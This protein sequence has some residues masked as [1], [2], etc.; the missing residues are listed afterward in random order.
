MKFRV[1]N[2]IKDA[3]K[4]YAFAQLSAV[5]IWSDY[6][7]VQRSIE[8]SPYFIKILKKDLNYWK[9]F[10]NK[11]KISN[12]I[13]LGA[14]VGEFVILIPVDKLCPKEKHGFKVDSLRETIRY[15]DSNEAYDYASEYMRQKY[16][17]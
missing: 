1:P 15:A 6:S 10:F 3:K 9:G 17:A 5:E 11:N 14:S 4:Q 13:K 7:Y 16:G 12:Y 8:K 2:I